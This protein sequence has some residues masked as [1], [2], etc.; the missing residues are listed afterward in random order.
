M[1]ETY[2]FVAEITRVV[3]QKDTSDWKVLQFNTQEPIPASKCEYGFYYSTMTGN[4]I[5]VESGDRVRV[6]AK[7]SN[8]TKYGKQFEIQSLK[9]D[10]PETEDDI[11][12]YLSNVISSNQAVTLYN[13]YPDII[14]K[15]LEDSKF[16]PDFKKLKGIGPKN[17]EKIKSKILINYGYSELISMLAPIGVTLPMIKKIAAGEKDITLLKHKI[18]QNPYILC[19]FKGL[20]FKKV[21]NYAI[22]LNP[23]LSHSVF[24]TISAIQYILKECANEEGHC[25][26]T[27]KNFVSKFM[28]L[29]PN[30]V[31]LLKDI[32]K[33]QNEAFNQNPHKAWLY[34][35]DNKVGLM[36]YYYLE[37]NICKKLDSIQTYENNW[38]I[39]YGEFFNRMEEVEKKQGFKLDEI[40]T[41]AVKSIA[42]NNVTII[43]GK[44]GCGKSS[45]LRAVLEVYKNAK[46]AMAALSAKAA[47]RI[48]EASGFYGASTIH[49]LLRYKN[50]E[51]EY[52]E[53]NYLP[54]N[55]LIID[56]VSMVNSELIYSC[57][58]AC[59]RD[60]KI[61]LVG[62][63]AQLPSI[64]VG[65]ILGDLLEF[66]RYN[67]RALNKLYRQS[68]ESYI[69]LH[70]NV[71]RDGIMPFDLNS[72]TLHFG[73]DTHY[74][75]KSDNEIIVQNIIDLYLAYLNHGLSY[76][77]ICIIIPRKENTVVSCKTVN[78]QLM[79]LLLQNETTQVSYN[80]KEFKLGCR[81]INK[82]ND[83]NKGILNGDQGTVSEI[84][85]DGTKFV[86]TLDITGDKISFNRS[87]MDSLELGYAITCHSSQGSQYKVCIIGMDFGSFTMLSS[88]LIYTAITRAKDKMWFVSEPRAFIKGV[89]N[90]TENQRNTFLS[91]FLQEDLKKDKD[92]NIFTD[93][94]SNKDVETT[95]DI[96]PDF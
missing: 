3:W 44:A 94:F 28:E 46:I 16:Q 95:G 1:S 38:N 37:Q 68:E 27:N 48:R 61:I 45:I 43:S 5:P 8:N 52:N 10:T 9:F 14:T 96:E 40:Q 77:D 71:I 93:D 64:G 74:I 49:R 62:D 72:S 34:V 83:Y 63:Q 70:A 82:V 20:G 47:K 13:V 18:E 6:V 15:V 2:S 79:N 29:I 54:Y 22:K 19:Q 24:R 67:N 32:L 89:N 75:F 81:V 17:W 90:V 35:K 23:E 7:L 60:T 78:N 76:E 73:S 42:D 50:G 87:E 51:W 58:S 31:D 84:S 55:L 26:L 59:S 85:E 39:T 69:A 4:C 21:D 57:L 56:E 25:Y 92:K 30:C 86:V 88:N 53:N 12:N 91:L 80:D 65:R 41:E 36:K 33:E 66:P 11:L